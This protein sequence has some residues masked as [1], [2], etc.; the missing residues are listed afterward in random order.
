MAIRD[1]IDG[2]R[3]HCWD[4]AVHTF[5]TAVMFERRARRR[6][7]ALQAL[8]FLGIGAPVALGGVILSFGL[9]ASYI[10]VLIVIAG[11]IGVVQLVASVWSLVAGWQD[12]L[13]F[14]LPAGIP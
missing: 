14:S 5:A 10:P 2:L 3:S 7:G 6:R 9:N 1:Q 4:E 11:V 8:N 13:S 12:D